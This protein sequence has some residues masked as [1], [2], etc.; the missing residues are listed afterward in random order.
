MTSFATPFVAQPSTV[1]KRTFS[2]FWLA[3]IMSCCIILAAKA[4]PVNGS[5][6]KLSDSTLC[7]I[8]FLL[9][10][11]RTTCK[12]QQD[13]IVMSSHVIILPL[14]VPRQHLLF[15][16]SILRTPRLRSVLLILLNALSCSAPESDLCKAA[17]ATLHGRPPGVLW[18][19]TQCRGLWKV[20][21]ISEWRDRLPFC[22]HLYPMT[23]SRLPLSTLSQKYE[24]SS[25]GWVVSIHSCHVAPSFSCEAL[26]WHEPWDWK[27]LAT[28]LERSMLCNSACRSRRWINHLGN[29]WHDRMP[30]SHACYSRLF[31]LLLFCKSLEMSSPF[32]CGLDGLLLVNFDWFPRVLFFS[33]V[34]RLSL[35][36]QTRHRC[37]RHR[38][39][40]CNSLGAHI[41]PHFLSHRQSSKSRY[42]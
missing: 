15:H 17:S 40:P 31:L 18:S 19:Q 4:F 33:S 16:L 23:T 5:L 37:Y 10:T 41:P 3:L 21:E 39:R 27:S 24:L 34:P 13:E 36:L 30:I 38:H 7:W 9:H 26:F 20:L 42:V 8:V 12:Q 22:R 14:Q 32:V 35:N 2:G 25:C 6:R 1:L 28:S 29:L 11:K